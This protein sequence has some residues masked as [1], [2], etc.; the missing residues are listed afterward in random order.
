MRKAAATSF[1]RRAV[2]SSAVLSALLGLTASFHLRQFIDLYR[3]YNPDQ[4][5]D[6]LGRWTATGGSETTAALA[7]V[8]TGDPEIDGLTE[9]LLD[10]LRRTVERVGPGSG[11]S[12]GTDIHFEFAETLHRANLPGVAVEVSFLKGEEVSYGTPESVR[13]DVLLREQGGAGPVKA[14]WDVKTGDARLRTG[15][16]AEIRAEFRLSREIPVFELNHIRGVTR[17][18]RIVVRRS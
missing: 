2:A 17:K 10:T 8:K 15:R 1:H 4:P 7:E 12:Y 11:A 9:T 6:E 14:A 16:A 3:K 18:H 5:R 13:V